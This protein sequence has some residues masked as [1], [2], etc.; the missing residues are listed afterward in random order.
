MGSQY[1]HS[2]AELQGIC[3]LDKGQVNGMD[4]E[5]IN[6]FRINEKVS[7]GLRFERPI[8]FA[9]DRFRQIP[10]LPIFRCLRFRQMR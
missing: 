10:E 7:R 4:W 6:S 1:C 2:P 9:Q 5:L 3:E 8:P